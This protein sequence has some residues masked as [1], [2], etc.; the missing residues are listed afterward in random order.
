MI[1]AVTYTSLGVWI[2]RAARCRRI[3]VSLMKVRLRSSLVVVLLATLPA[4][5]VNAPPVAERT[6]D[7][8]VRV[9][10][11]QVDTVYAVPG[12]SL[13]PYKRVMLDSVDLAFKLDWQKRHPEVSDSDVT[14]SVPRGPRFSTRYSRRRSRREWLSARLAACARR[15]ARDRVDHQNSTSARRSTAWATNACT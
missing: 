11:K 7:G 13:A 8:L 14:V 4:C 2:S 3:E 15:A 10:G 9:Q 1:L 12:V 5:V 6:P